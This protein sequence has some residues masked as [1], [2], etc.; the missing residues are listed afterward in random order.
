METNFQPLLGSITLIKDPYITNNLIINN[1]IQREININKKIYFL[2]GIIQ[3]PF[4]MNGGQVGEDIDGAFKDAISYV[5]TA[6]GNN[7]N[8]SDQYI[9]STNH[10]TLIQDLEEN[11]FTRALE[12]A[13]NLHTFSEGRSI[14]RIVR[15]SG[16]S[17]IN[18][19]FDNNLLVR[20]NSLIANGTPIKSNSWWTAVTAHLSAHGALD[21][22]PPNP[23]PNPSNYRPGVFHLKLDALVGGARGPDPKN[24]VGYHWRLNYTEPPPNGRFYLSIREIVS[25]VNQELAE[26]EPTRL[27]FN[28]INIFFR[29]IDIPRET[30]EDGDRNLR[31][32]P[33]RLQT[34][35][36][37]PAGGKSSKKQRKTKKTRRTKKSKKTRKHRTR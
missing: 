27:I 31:R 8:A 7:D 24:T 23:N 34:R 9:P 15:R 33:Q 37:N 28:E 35:F 4:K 6:L 21:L 5:L 17:F 19:F 18:F 22:I 14:V 13:L 11:N 2:G 10:L 29:T 20:Y 30:L 16:E 12:N 25:A 36:R 26:S 32:L 3:I 1:G